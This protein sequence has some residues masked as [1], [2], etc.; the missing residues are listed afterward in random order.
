M[1][2]FQNFVTKINQR[3]L[4]FSDLSKL[5]LKMNHVFRLFL[6]PL[7]ICLSSLSAFTIDQN[8]KSSALNV[9]K[10]YEDNNEF[11]LD[12]R[13]AR[14]RFPDEND[15][16]KTDDDLFFALEDDTKWKNKKR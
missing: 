3:F 1:L 15:V 13:E 12:E 2:S 16:G 10:K 7:A 9:G 5:V 14:E 11:V 6:L 4:D 8:A